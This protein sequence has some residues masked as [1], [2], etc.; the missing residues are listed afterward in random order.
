MQNSES[1]IKRNEQD[2]KELWNAVDDIKKM[3]MYHLPLWATTLI[4]LLT[5][6]CGFL[7]R[8]AL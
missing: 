2:I 6:V 5:G 8:M 7:L 1:R 4:A 3:M